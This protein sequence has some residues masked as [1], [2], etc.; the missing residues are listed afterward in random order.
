MHSLILPAILEASTSLVTVPD[1]EVLVA[2]M[3]VD[4]SESSTS[5]TLASVPELALVTLNF[6]VVPPAAPATVMVVL[7]VVERR[8]AVNT[9]LPGVEPMLLLHSW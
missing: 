3:S 4:P 2:M 1:V 6:R 9:P 8:R 5:V 7:G